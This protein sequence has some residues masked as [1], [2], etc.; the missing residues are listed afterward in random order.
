MI[1]ME[2]PA[3]CATRTVTAE[4]G[5]FWVGFPLIY[6]GVRSRRWTGCAAAVEYT[7]FCRTTE[8][9]INRRRLLILWRVGW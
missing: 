8:Q 7:H 9:R 5:S 1:A 6:R 3:I 2:S 4:L